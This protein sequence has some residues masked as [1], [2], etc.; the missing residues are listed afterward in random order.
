VGRSGPLPANLVQGAKTIL[1][2][3]GPVWAMQR[4]ET[5]IQMHRHSSGEVREWLEDHDPTR[6]QTQAPQNLAQLKPLTLEVAANPAAKE[7]IDR[8]SQEYEF[9]EVTKIPAAQ[10]VAELAKSGAAMP[11]AAGLLKPSALDDPPFLLGQQ[12]LSPEERGN[13]VHLF[14]QHV[15][16]SQSADSLSGQLSRLVERKIL[17]EAQVDAIDVDDV[18]WLLGS[19]LG[20]LLRKNGRSVIRELPVNFPYSTKELAEPL[21]RTMLRGRI[22][23]LVPDERGFT[24]VDYKTDD[25]RSRTS[26]QH[27]ADFYRPQL[28]LYG[29]AIKSITGRAVHTAHLVFL[30]AHQIV[31][32][33][34]SPQARTIPS[35]G[36]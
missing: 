10:P 24:L 20:Q 1:D 6:P 23:L 12:P 9:K 2:W 16:F 22:D 5:A 14:L 4:E 35:N 7:V 17:S 15:D 33:R 8:L 13:A 27:R 31:T 11:A 19:E 3:V 32:V 34:T 29:Q 36:A 30:S 28:E 21:D 25:V 26:L 18:A